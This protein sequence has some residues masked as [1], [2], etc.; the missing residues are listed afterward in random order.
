MLKD[1]K[2]VL[3]RRRAFDASDL[4]RDPGFD[5]EE[6]DEIPDGMECHPVSIPK[7]DRRSGILRIIGRRGVRPR[8]K[9]RVTFSYKHRVR[10][11]DDP[12]VLICCES[13]EEICGK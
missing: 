1:E 7:R 10:W 6:L 8:S 13:A 2:Y 11:F 3:V 9:P 5:I 4:T 12:H